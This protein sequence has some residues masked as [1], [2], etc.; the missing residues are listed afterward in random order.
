MQCFRTLQH[1][2]NLYTLLRLHSK[3]GLVFAVDPAPRFCEFLQLYQKIFNEICQIG[4]LLAQ[5]DE[6]RI[7]GNPVDENNQTDVFKPP[8]YYLETIFVNLGFD[9]KLQ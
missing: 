1:N 2:F 4:L 9:P 5:I 3:K 6:F 8:L 7:S